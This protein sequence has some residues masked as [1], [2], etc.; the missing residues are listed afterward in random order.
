MSVYLIDKMGDVKDML[1]INAS[2]RRFFIYLDFYKNKL[3][4]RYNERLNKL[5][6]GSKVNSKMIS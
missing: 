5:R 2:E 4:R 1:K 6:R 3:F